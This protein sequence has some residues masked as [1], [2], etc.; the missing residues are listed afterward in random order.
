MFYCVVNNSLYHRVPYHLRSTRIF[1]LFSYSNIFVRYKRLFTSGQKRLL[2]KRF[3]SLIGSFSVSSLLIFEET[4]ILLE[5]PFHAELNGVC[6][7]SVY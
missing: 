4:Y 1:D 7:N 6:P 3:K 5:S 2:V